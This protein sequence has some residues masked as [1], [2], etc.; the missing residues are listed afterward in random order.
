MSST[1]VSQAPSSVAKSFRLML[2]QSLF[3]FFYLAYRI[4]LF[5]YSRY[6]QYRQADPHQI[7]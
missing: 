2:C 7:F 3:C 1:L 4:F 6:L 5:F